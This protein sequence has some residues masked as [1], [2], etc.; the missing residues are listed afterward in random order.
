MSDI[1]ILASTEFEPGHRERWMAHIDDL[2]EASRRE[3]GVHR[4]EVVAD[5]KS[6]TRVIAHEHYE[7]TAAL[8]AHRTSEHHARFV[9]ATKDCRVSAR[10][11]AVFEA[12]R[13]R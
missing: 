8:E 2:V 7:D 13:L 9:S 1:V 11:I 5:P 6:S 4:Y 10:D 3:P 12:K